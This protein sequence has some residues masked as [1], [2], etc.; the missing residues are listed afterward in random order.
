MSETD[1]QA[2]EVCACGLNLSIWQNPWNHRRGCP[3]Q[4]APDALAAARA[5]GERLRERIEAHARDLRAAGDDR[6]MFAAAA[7]LAALDPGL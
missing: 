5:E 6:S 1:Q 2:A 3:M 7:L 4:P